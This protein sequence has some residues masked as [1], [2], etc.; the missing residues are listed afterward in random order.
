MQLV[1]LGPAAANGAVVTDTLPAG[2]TTPQL[3]A[4]TAAG[5]ASCPALVLPAAV[6]GPWTIPTLPAGGGVTLT[7]VG[8]APAAIGTLVNLVSVAPPAGIS[9]PNASND[10]SQ[11]ATQ[12]IT[13]PARRRRWPILAS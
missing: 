5:G 3:T 9:D 12:V 6:T 1:N 7:V 2:L 4:C 13:S 11:I 8:T 10:T